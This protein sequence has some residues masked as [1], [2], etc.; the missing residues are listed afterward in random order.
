[1]SPVC[2]LQLLHYFMQYYQVYYI[3]TLVGEH[4]DGQK[5]GTAVRACSDVK[6]VML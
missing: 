5:D 6:T 4:N 1:M 2:F 3:T